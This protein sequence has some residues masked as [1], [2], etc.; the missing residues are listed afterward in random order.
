MLSSKLLDV[1]RVLGKFWCKPHANVAISMVYT[2]YF[3]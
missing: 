2:P 1:E 3:H